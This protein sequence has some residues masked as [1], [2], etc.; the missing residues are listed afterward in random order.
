MNKNPSISIQKF[1]HILYSCYDLDTGYKHTKEIWTKENKYLG[2]CAVTAL[3]VNDYYGG[4]IKRGYIK[5]RNM[6]HYWNFIN[7]EKIDLTIEQIGNCPS[8]EI[9]KIVTK[10]RNSLL[11]V[12]SVLDRYLLLQKKVENRIKEWEDLEKD[13]SL[14]RNCS[15]ESYFEHD[16]VHFG[17]N[18]ELLFIGEAPARNGWRITGKAWYNPKGEL[19]PSGKIFSK[20]LKI[21]NVELEDTT[22]VEAVKCY[23]KNGKIIKKYTDNCISFL[24]RQLKLLDPLVVIPMG[25]NATKILFNKDIE[26]FEVV[27]KFSKVEI[28]GT[29]FLVFPIYH[30]SPISPKSL[31][32]NVPIFKT[33]EK[34]L[35][36]IDKEKKAI[37]L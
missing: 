24:S 35:L 23:P 15:M 37:K 4:I 5:D 10:S 8:D 20:L 36:D 30:P 26:F 22:F 33:L 9:E 1:K 27:G 21:I 31:K 13:I 17:N 34:F 2:Q 25:V 7:G 3:L 6:Y 18:C 29:N 28:D 16:S 19:V 32:D 12:S 11:K 14:C